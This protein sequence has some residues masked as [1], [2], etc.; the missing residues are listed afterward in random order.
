MTASN[1][2]TGIGFIA[3]LLWSLLA[4]ATSG[5]HGIPAFQLLAMTFT[6][7]FV[8]SS[9]ILYL[10]GD[11]AHR[12]WRVP[13]AAWVLSVGGLFGYH[14]FYF[15]ALS[16]A[17]AVEASLI[18][19]LWPLFIVLFSNLLPGQHLR[20]PHLVGAC[21]SFAG[22]VLL[23]GGG[24][25]FQWRGEA[26]LGYGYAFVCALLWSG[27]SVANRRFQAIPAQ[28]VSGYCA[29]VALLAAVAHLSL[30]AT[31]APSP[32]QWAWVLALGIGPVGVA[33]FFWDYGTKH[34]NLALLG[35]LSYAAP[36]LSTLLLIAFGKAAFTVSVLIAAVL[37]SAG[38]LLASRR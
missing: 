24:E 36:L 1:H 31:V 5:T 10:K 23:I 35:T 13:L 21:I 14:F 28:S 29:V 19:Y 33:F 17:P 20:W 2:A 6:V 16:L 3:I 8:V 38:A 30:E 22:A 7:A 9:A 18:A 15:R 32:T 11:P 4:L 26:A 34:G 12:Y 37:I 25:A 27:Y